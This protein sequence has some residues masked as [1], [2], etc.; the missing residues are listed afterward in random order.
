MF[1]LPRHRLTLRSLFQSGAYVKFIANWSDNYPVLFSAFV[2]V[3]P[4]LLSLLL[5]LFLPVVIRLVTRFRRLYSALT[6]HSLQMD[7]QSSRSNDPL[8]G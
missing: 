7:R 6:L 1:L 3:V 8:A 5:Q 4:P 2:G